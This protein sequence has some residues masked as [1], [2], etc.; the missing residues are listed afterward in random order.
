MALAITLA[1]QAFACSYIA[2]EQVKDDKVAAG[3]AGVTGAAIHIASL[4]YG[5]VLGI[6]CCIFLEAD[7]LNLK[8]RKAQEKERKEIAM[9]NNELKK[10][11]VI[12]IDQ[13]Y[14]SGGE[15]IARK[16]ANALSVPCYSKEILEEAAKVSGISEKLFF[17]YDERTVD[18]A[19]NLNADDYSKVKMP[20]TGDMVDAQ[21]MAVKRLAD[22]G[23]C[24]F[25]DRNAGY[26]LEDVSY[27]HLAGVADSPR[28][29]N[30]PIAAANPQRTVG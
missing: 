7:P 3:I 21:I 11:L 20:T 13:E 1:V 2:I 27:T 28:R 10:H 12:A 30:P 15:E 16:L 29:G 23:S 22:Q 25:V 19:Y 14:M 5:L 18:K 24:V 9:K 6:I 4:N 8:A 17:K 26:A